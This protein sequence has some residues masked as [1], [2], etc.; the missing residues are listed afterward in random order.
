ML[1]HVHLVY[2]KAFTFGR[3]EWVLPPRTERAGDSDRHLAAALS[4]TLQNQIYM[5]QIARILLVLAVGLGCGIVNV[6]VRRTVGET[7]GMIV[8]VIDTL[9]LIPFTILVMSRD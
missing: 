3:L 2:T 6:I 5:R 1:A 4:F 8:C 7:A 9:L